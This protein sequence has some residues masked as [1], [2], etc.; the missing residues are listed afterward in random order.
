MYK[1]LTC[2]E[3]QLKEGVSGSFFRVLCVLSVC[4]GLQDV[5]VRSF[6]HPSVRPSIHPSRVRVRVR[7]RFVFGCQECFDRV[8]QSSVFHL[9]IHVCL[10]CRVE[11]KRAEM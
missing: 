4:V 8:C 7:V 11:R 10:L 5:D 6:V 2:W 1:P 9:S 3:L